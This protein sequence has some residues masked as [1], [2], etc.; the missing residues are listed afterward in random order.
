MLTYLHQSILESDAQ[1]VVNTVNTVGVMGKGLAKE[2]R[3]R[4]PE[5]YKRYRELCQEGKFTIGQL[6][7]WKEED[8][9]VLN[10]PTKTTWRR[11]SKLEYIEAGLQKF[12]D[13]YEIRGITEI[14]FPRLGCGNGGLDWETQVQPLMERYLQPLPIDVY[15]H[16]HHQDIGLPEHRDVRPASYNRSYEALIDG[17]KS[18]A[19]E[20]HGR[21]QTLEWGSPFNA[22]V[23]EGELE[24]VY[25]SGERERASRVL[26]EELLDLWSLL[27]K[28]PVTEWTL[29]GKAHEEARYVLSVLSSLP[30][31]RPVRLQ[32]SGSERELV[33]IEL[34]DRQAAP[35]IAQDL[36]TGSQASIEWH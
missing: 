33:G 3:Q 29:A 26:K 15:I 27:L 35:E 13:N 10:F 31:I 22:R 23:V 25:L 28:G 19:S 18:L 8:Q 24:I 36:R 17:L 9:W 1:T 16:N 21:F 11:P 6:W 20:K 4:H 12:V 30:F 7:L 32:S 5:M 2:F 14:A 34:L